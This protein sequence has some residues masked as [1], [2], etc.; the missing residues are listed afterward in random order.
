MEF[1]LLSDLKRHDVNAVVQVSVIRKLDFRGI[2]D[3]GPIQHVDMV[4]AD[5]KV[6]QFC[7]A[8]SLIDILGS[9]E[10][11]PLL[12]LT[13]RSFICSCTKQTMKQ[14]N[15]IYAE[16]PNNLVVEKIPRIQMNKAYDIQRCKVLPVSSLYKP[17]Q[18]SFMIQFTVY[19]ET[20][21]VTDPAATFPSYIYKLHTF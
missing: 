5:K 21:V 9:V 14:G 3:N 11:Q 13:V 6:Q 16:V 8:H 1:T 12:P 20:Q 19:T 4:L 15:A 17:V 10:I 18:A 2:S 7:T